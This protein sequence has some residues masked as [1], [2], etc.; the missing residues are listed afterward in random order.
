MAVKWAVTAAG[1]VVGWGLLAVFWVKLPPLVPLWYSRPWG[2]EQL[3][4]P[5]FL[6]VIP[7]AILVLGG[8]GEIVRRLVND[9]VLE[10]MLVWAVVGAQIIL[11]VGLAR[12]II[13]V[14]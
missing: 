5:A 3:A 6:W 1:A 12:I 11:T 4:N 7:A 14:V 8:G 10:T 13:L 2:E 9:K